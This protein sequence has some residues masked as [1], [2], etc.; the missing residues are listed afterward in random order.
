MRP[1]VSWLFSSITTLLHHVH[2][3]GP[4]TKV[5]YCHLVLDLLWSFQFPLLCDIF[6]VLLVRSEGKAWGKLLASQVVTFVVRRLWPVTC[7]C[8]DCTWRYGCPNLLS[9]A[10][11]P[12]V[13]IP[14]AVEV[15]GHLSFSFSR[16]SKAGQPSMETWVLTS[17]SS[18]EM[19]GFVSPMWGRTE[20]I[21]TP[22][23][24]QQDL[25]R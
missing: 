10:C 13:S 9:Q 25:T 20:P 18:V 16:F 12:K 2:S 21:P 7:S 8:L 19:L 17:I 3:P 6:C 14:K 22:Q 4:Q 24:T 11:R 15:V 23:P 5:R 1:L